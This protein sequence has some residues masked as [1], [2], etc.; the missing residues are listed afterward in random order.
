MLYALYYPQTFESPNEAPE[1]EQSLGA[2]SL[3][4]PVHIFHYTIERMR[5]V[6][7]EWRSIKAPLFPEYIF[8]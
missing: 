2:S 5:H 6:Q 1:S 4:I 7:G 8:F 3:S